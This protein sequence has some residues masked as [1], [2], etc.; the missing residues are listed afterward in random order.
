MRRVYYIIYMIEDPEI[1]EIICRWIK[2]SSI[3]YVYLTELHEE[4]LN[5]INE[6]GKPNTVK[7]YSVSFS[8][9]LQES[10]DFPI[11]INLRL[12]YRYSKLSNILNEILSFNSFNEGTLRVINSDLIIDKPLRGKI[13]PLISRYSYYLNK[14]YEKVSL[15]LNFL[16]NNFSNLS[17]KEIESIIK[18]NE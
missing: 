6:L 15:L 11:P 18:C 2:E 4:L 10:F 9:V 5:K 8:Y 14:L 1:C 17:S 16:A 12:P 3:E 7:P 13:C